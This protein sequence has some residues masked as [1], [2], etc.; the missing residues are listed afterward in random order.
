MATSISKALSRTAADSFVRNFNTESG[1]FYT[2]FMG[3]DNPSQVDTSAN[4]DSPN[5]QTAVSEH[6]TFF[7][8]IKNSEVQM[9][10]DRY[11]YTSN[12][13]YF[14]YQSSGQ[15]SGEEQ[16]YV[17]NKTNKTVYLC[18]GD[19]VDNRYDL[20]GRV[21]SS[22]APT[23]SEG[24]KTYPDGYTWLV[25]YKVDWKLTDFLTSKYLPVP[26]AVGDAKLG[27]E[28]PGVDISKSATLD[29]N[30]TRFCGSSKTQCGS[31][32]LFHRN[33]WTDT[34]SGLTYDVGD[35]YQSLNT[36]CY[37][38][39]ELSGRLD[40]D[41]SF[42]AGGTGS[43]GSCHPCS[44]TKCPCS[45]TPV[46][47]IATIKTSN[48]FS[49]ADNAK[50]QA[51]IS[52][53][54]K[55]GSLLS[56][57]ID[58]NGVTGRQKIV[59]S[60]NP[61][62]TITSSSGT[63]VVV[64]LLTTKD[65][66][67][68]HIVHGVTISN[69]GEGYRDHLIS[70]LNN[71]DGNFNIASKITLNFETVDNVINPQEILNAHCVMFNVSMTTDEIKNVT[72]QSNFE[73]FGFSKNAKQID[74]NGNSTPIGSTTPTGVASFQRATHK[75]T[76]GKLVT[77]GAAAFGAAYET[78]ES[79]KVGTSDD[80]SKV[81][82]RNK[83]GSTKGEMKISSVEKLN[84]TT[85]RLE[86]YPQSRRKDSDDRTELSNSTRLINQADTETINLITAK[87][88]SPVVDTG[89]IIHTG[90]G[91]NFK[92]PP[93]GQNSVVRMRVTKCF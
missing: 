49:S 67:N 78:T 82:T 89:K 84:P 79:G 34:V 48:N 20:R 64:K 80:K 2:I 59:S 71:S 51:N 75:I 56:A 27:P 85:T 39:I 69:R 3:G 16:C 87:E 17:Y 33:A 73:F 65:A 83:I 24:Y 60:A 14:H 41:Y 23:H 44:V 40:L 88:I 35:L 11:D 55:D 52:S 21:V 46:D 38:C 61:E 45:K 68:N 86:L 26:A 90:T 74:A 7:R 30:A 54:I 22:H 70:T 28:I 4:L 66:S 92:M 29:S 76:V 91:L 58:L 31:C 63:G 53:L 12:R 18:V 36:K 25:L 43:T 42:I 77:Q 6:T 10:V 32:C 37:E 72:D 81:Q 50:T 19:N 47:R 9:V 1:G 62:V 57:T 93:H 13:A 8:T 15:P 5:V